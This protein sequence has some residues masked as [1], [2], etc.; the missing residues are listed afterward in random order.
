[1]A[2][3]PVVQ[4]KPTRGM[5]NQL[6]LQTLQVPSSVESNLSSKLN[7]DTALLL[8]AN[9]YNNRQIGDLYSVTFQSIGHRLNKRGVYRKDGTGEIVS[10]NLKDVEYKKEDELNDNNYVRKVL[11]DV[12]KGKAKDM[13]CKDA[14]WSYA[15]LFDKSQ[16]MKGEATVIVNYGKNQKDVAGIDEE[17]QRLEDKLAG[18]KPV[19]VH[20]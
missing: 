18:L 3:N 15:V 16:I 9:G 20:I 7:D 14:T 4:A 2:D 12:I 19:D 13:N 10:F 1:M 17:I 5:L 11:M 8:A 6:V